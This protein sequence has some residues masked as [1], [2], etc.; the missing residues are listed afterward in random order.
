MVFE[1]ARVKSMGFG[2]SCQN[3]QD[4]ANKVPA[5]PD[6]YQKQSAMTLQV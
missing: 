1:T 4:G 5:S 6:R 3:L 2:G